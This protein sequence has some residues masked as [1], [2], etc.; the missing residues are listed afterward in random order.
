MNPSDSDYDEDEGSAEFEED[1]D[2]SGGEEDYDVGD[3]DDDA[4]EEA[5]EMEEGSS[6]KTMKNEQN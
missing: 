6:T 1:V 2:D 4:F 3:D 5:F